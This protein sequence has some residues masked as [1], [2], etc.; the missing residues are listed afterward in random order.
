[1]K[2]KLIVLAVFFALVMC[3][4]TVN[5]YS[6][7]F[8]NNQPVITYFTDGTYSIAIDNGDKTKTTTYYDSMGGVIRVIT[9]NVD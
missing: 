8:T 4:T 1:M 9:Q 3:F 2:F 5:T 7:P 6:A